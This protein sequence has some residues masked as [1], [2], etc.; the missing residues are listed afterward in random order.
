MS[1]LGYTGSTSQADELVADHATSTNLAK[2]RICIHR[3]VIMFVEGADFKKGAAG[4]PASTYHTWSGV[5]LRPPRV[6]P[7]SD[8]YQ[9]NSIFTI[10]GVFQHYFAQA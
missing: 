1:M 2:K 4:L 5:P 3:M 10:F 9:V 6:L 8:H 7:A